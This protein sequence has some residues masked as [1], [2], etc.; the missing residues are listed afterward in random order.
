MARAASPQSPEPEGQER[1]SVLAELPHTRPQRPSARRETARKRAGTGP[2]KQEPSKP[3][4]STARAQ[5]ATPSPA[6]R[7]SDAT[8]PASQPEATPTAPRPK[9]ASQTKPKPR[10]RRA[11]VKP[12][13]PPQGYE[14]DS[15]LT[16]SPVSPPSGT[17]VVGALAELAGELAHTSITAGGR[18]LRSA[19]GRLS[20]S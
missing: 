19:L 20:S 9:A 12:P 14:A 11:P 4:T 3:K 18:L 17:E 1:H 15:E 2:R 10:S 13:T 6:A 5:R 16:G 7:R 8:P